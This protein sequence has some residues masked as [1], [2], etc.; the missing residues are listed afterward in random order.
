[1]CWLDLLVSSSDLSTSRAIL[2]LLGGLLTSFMKDAWAENEID[3][4]TKGKGL[5]ADTVGLVL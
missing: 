4:W 5:N 1:M 3:S 2:Y